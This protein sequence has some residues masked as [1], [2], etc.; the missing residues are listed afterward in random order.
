MHDKKELSDKLTKELTAINT[1]IE[2]VSEKYSLTFKEVI[3]IISKGI[4]KE[5]VILIPTFIFRN[6]NLGI[7]ESVTKYLKEEL[8]ITYHEIAV[9]LNRDDRVIWV[10]YNKARK[11]A[12]ERFVIGKPSLWIEISIFRDKQQGLLEC[13]ARHL[14]DVHEMRYQEIAELLNRDNRTIWSSYNK[15]KK[16]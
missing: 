7:L 13:I 8:N 10:S 9:M 15:R 6:R 16:V 11:K 2:T 3:E 14:K 12:K 4:E 1:F 5:K